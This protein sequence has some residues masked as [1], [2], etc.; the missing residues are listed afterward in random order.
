MISQDHSLAQYWC[1]GMYAGAL[2]RM[3]QYDK[4]I[5]YSARAFANCPDQKMEAMNTYL[6]SNRN[7][8]SAL[9]LCKDASDSVYVAMLEGANEPLPNMEFA[10]MV[11]QKNHGS[12]ILKFLWLSEAHKME[13]DWVT[14]FGRVKETHSKQALEHNQLEGKTDQLRGS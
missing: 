7:W 6:F 5:Y 3:K 11:Y 1:E 2:L 9:P 12:E 4:A 14:T 8:K 10:N 13:E